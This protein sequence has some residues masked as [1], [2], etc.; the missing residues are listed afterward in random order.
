MHARARTH[1]RT[2]AHARAGAHTHTRGRAGAR[3]YK[4]ARVYMRVLSCAGRARALRKK[5]AL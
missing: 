2:H 5:S 3:F 1:A 4:G